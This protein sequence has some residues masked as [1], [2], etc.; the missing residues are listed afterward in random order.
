M[1][2]FVRLTNEDYRPFDFMQQNVKRIIPPGGEAIVPWDIAVTLFGHPRLPNIPPANERTKMYE[3][4]RA[5]HNFSAG[6]MQE[7]EWEAIRP[8]ITVMDLEDNTRI[9]M[10]I[11]DPDGTNQPDSVASVNPAANDV[12][13]LQQQITM[14]TAQVNKMVMMQMANQAPAAPG[15]A[16]SPTAVA[17]SPGQQQ[18]ADSGSFAI[19]TGS[20]GSAT[21]DTPQ[22]TPVA[23]QQSTAAPDTPPATSGRR[24][25]PKPTS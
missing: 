16:Q 7:G 3:K 15:T 25:A 20:T 14:L 9:T 2:Q 1:P 21:P 5:R 17:D 8:H 6:L 13:T 10:L 11:D 18:S 12:A 4:I 23:T 24:P 19:P 22:A